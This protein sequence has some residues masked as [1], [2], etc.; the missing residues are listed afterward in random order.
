MLM[1][2]NLHTF[3]Q[4]KILDFGDLTVWKALDF[5]REATSISA[6]NLFVVISGYFSIKWKLK[7]FLSLIFQVFFWIFLIY[8]TLISTNI[9]DFDLKNFVV[10]SNFIATAYWFITV[11]IGLYLLSPLLNIH[12]EIVFIS[13]G[14]KKYLYYVILFFF[15]QFY[16]QLCGSSSFMNGYSILSFCGC[17]MIGRYIR[18]TDLTLSRSTTVWGIL[19]TTFLIAISGIVGRLFGKE[20]FIYNQPFVVAQTIFIFCFFKGLTLQSRVINYCA[21]SALAIYLLHMH[22]DLKQYFYA[23]AKEL[24][25]YPIWQHLVWLLV[26]FTVIFIAAIAIDKLRLVVFELL[27]N[28]V[29]NQIYRWKKKKR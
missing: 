14:G 10:R 24:Y 9:I 26:V 15:L 8:I 6:V 12:A 20:L 21:S 7:S 3:S 5:F 27:Y 29:E 1:V 23:F 28:R 16:Y 22:P 13:G 4:P 25:N 19:I 11:Y 18:L 2:M 17:Y